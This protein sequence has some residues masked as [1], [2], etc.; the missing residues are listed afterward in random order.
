MA[1]K[2]TILLYARV[3]I[4]LIIIVLMGVAA[5]G[6]MIVRKGDSEDYVNFW[7]AKTGGVTV[8]TDDINCSLL[9]SRLKACA[10]LTVVSIIFVFFSMLL[11]LGQA[12]APRIRSNKVFAVILSFFELVAW[13]LL[14]AAWALMVNFYHGNWCASFVPK[15]DDYKIGYGLG[16]LIAMWCLQIVPPILE[17]LSHVVSGPKPKAVDTQPTTNVSDVSHTSKSEPVA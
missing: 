7:E 17:A 12:R 15:D 2:A 5:D 4:W 14:L 8:E 11:G 13:A 10:G 6:K 16:L 1:D 9:R 3:V